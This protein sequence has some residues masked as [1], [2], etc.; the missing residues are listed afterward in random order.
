MVGKNI[1]LDQSMIFLAKYLPYLIVLAFIFWFLR[2][3]RKNWYIFSISLGLAIVARFGIVFL[4]RLFYYHPRPFVV[5]DDI[6]QLLDYNLSSSFPSGHAAFFFAL[7]TGTHLFN[8]KAG[9][10]LLVLAGLNG[11]ARVFV[12]IHWPADVLFGAFIGIL[13]TIVFKKVYTK[14][15]SH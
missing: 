9:T 5:L 13:V 7:A 2:N 10:V 1:L 14:F 4:I 3:R 15:L 6:G 12:G 11:F 8:K